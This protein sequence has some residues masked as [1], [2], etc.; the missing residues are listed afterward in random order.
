MAPKGAVRKIVG[1]VISPLLANIALHGLEEV[2]VTAFP[3]TKSVGGNK[4]I[5]QPTV[6]RYADDLVVLHQD[7]DVVRRCR[8]II[9]GWLQG[10]GLELKPSK[11]FLT[12]TLEEHE[13]RVGFD[14]L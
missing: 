12:H 3:K 13:G 7:A 14:F 10:M 1:G 8:D 9:A 4:Q 5:W 6:I 11:T 2:V